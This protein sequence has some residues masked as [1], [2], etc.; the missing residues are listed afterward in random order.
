MR[1]IIELEVAKGRNGFYVIKNI[2]SNNLQVESD[3]VKIT[4]NKDEWRDIK[5]PFQLNNFLAYKF[6]AV[7]NEKVPDVE[8]W[9]KLCD[10]VCDKFFEE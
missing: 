4:M 7:K 3:W 10:A 5:N 1:K 8:Y 6:H 2:H 9:E